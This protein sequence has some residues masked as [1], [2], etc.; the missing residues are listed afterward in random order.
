MKNEGSGAG[1]PASGVDVA[2]LPDRIVLIGMMGSGKSTTG[3]LLASRL[4]WRY[5]D[6]D[7]DVRTL[8]DQEPSDVIRLRGEHELHAAEA[9]AFL[10]ALTSPP[11]VVIAAAAGVVLDE[12]CEEALRRQASVVYLRA[13]P[14]TLRRRI[15]TGLGRR[16]DATD[17]QWLEARSRERDERY[18][19]L[20][21]AVVDVDERT[22]EE[23]AERILLQVRETTDDRDVH[24][25]PGHAEGDPAP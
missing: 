11:P 24:P 2:R 5:L 22:P 21:T 12:T 20:A 14:E 17:L 4:G 8:T 6:N 15:G 9:S 7:E 19:S 25:V 23:V 16:S 13:R 10:R 3:R 18:R 1:H